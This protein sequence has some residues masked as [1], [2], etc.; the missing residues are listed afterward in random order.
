MK[1]LTTI[2]LAGALVAAALVGGTLISAAFASSA[3]TATSALSDPAADP[4][5]SPRTK[6]ER[7]LESAYG[8]AFLDRLA[9]E[10]GV[11]RAKLG[12]ATLA[13][14]NAAIDA[15]VAAGDLD[16]DRAAKL[17]ERLAGLDDPSVLLVRPG[18]GHGPRDGHGPRGLKVAFGLGLADTIDAA[19]DALKM[20]QPDLLVAIRDGKS[21]KE[22]AAGQKVDYATVTKAILDTVKTRLA[23]EVA[24]KDLTQAQSD[25]ILQ[26]VTDWLNA[27]GEFPKGRWF[28]R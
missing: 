18:F 3:P 10:L 13:A 12:S 22:I 23:D 20:D 21:L 1:P 8:K 14:T 27:G 6:G 2:G 15:A 25:R 24:D 26:K 19:A 5:A 28:H 7:I 9:Q 11:D 16:A 17:K 4:T